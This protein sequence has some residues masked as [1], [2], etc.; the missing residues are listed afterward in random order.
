MKVIIVTWLALSLAAFLL[1]GCFYPVFPD[2]G[3][4]GGG[5]RAGQHGGYNHNDGHHEDR[6]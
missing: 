4:Y 3:G 2:N 6:R 1:S 5:W